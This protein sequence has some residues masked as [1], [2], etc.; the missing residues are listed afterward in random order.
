M[1]ERGYLQIGRIRG[2]PLRIHWTMPLG[3][4]LFSGFSFAPAFWVGFFVVVLVHELGHAVLAR[5]YRLHVLAIDI[6]GFGGLTRFAGS[7]TRHERSVIA[8]GGVLAQALLFVLTL[9]VA[10]VTGPPRSWM[11]A[12]LVAVFT[13]ANLFIIG[14]NL[15]PF[16]PLDGAQ[17]WRLVGDLVRR[18]RGRGRSG[19]G[20][21][22][23]RRSSRPRSPGARTPRSPS[24]PGPDRDLADSLRRIAEQAGDARRGSSHR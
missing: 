9:G 5:R 19:S 3:A 16:P 7:T 17:A 2:I 6:T 24:S 15:L 20:R 21:G 11:L 13:T 22:A 18:W 1:F 4:L 10:F 8:W 14:L 23:G 12:Q